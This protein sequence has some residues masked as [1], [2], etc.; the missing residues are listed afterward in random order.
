[1]SWKGK[2]PSSEF[3]IAAQQLLPYAARG[4]IKDLNK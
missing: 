3:K 2:L 4:W 1:M